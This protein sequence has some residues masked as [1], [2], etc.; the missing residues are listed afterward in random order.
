MEII[1]Y[2]L[3][4]SFLRS[5]TYGYGELK[6]GDVGKARTCDKGAV[7]ASGV[8]FN[9]D[10]ASVAVSAP[11]K[12]RL[13][14]QWIRL[15]VAGGKCHKLKLLDKMHPRYIGERGFDLTPAAVRLLTGKAAAPNWSGRVELCR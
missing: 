10:V 4:A 6:C 13:K 7:T 1:K 15:R 12:L 14:S 2:L 5:T 9:P 11:F 8:E 3:L